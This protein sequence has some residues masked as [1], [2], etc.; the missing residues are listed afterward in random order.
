MIVV[1]DQSTDATA[2]IARRRRRHRGRRATR[3]PDGWAGKA[4]ALQQ[5]ID[6]ARANGSSRS[7]PTPGPTPGCPTAAGRPA[8]RRRL[9][10]L[11]V[12]GRFE[13]PTPGRRW[14]H[15]S[16]LTTLVYRF[17]P[18]GTLG[19]HAEPH[20]GER[21]VHGVPSRPFL[22]GRR[23][24]AV[25]GEVVEDVALARHLA[26][27]GAGRSTFLDAADR[28][29][30]CG[31]SSRSSDVPDGLG[32]LARPARCR[33][34]GTG[35]SSTSPSSCSPRRSRCRGC[36]PGVPMPSTSCCSPCVPARSSAPGP[37]TP[38][39]GRLLVLAGSRPRRGRRDRARHRRPAPDLARSQLP[40][41]SGVGSAS[42]GR[43]PGRPGRRTRPSRSADRS[44]SSD[45]RSPRS[46]TGRRPRAARAG[47]RT[48]RPGLP[49][50]TSAPR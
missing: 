30:P 28:C 43:R 3:C 6:A 33:A 2:A 34:L 22:A 21:A 13:C 19:R 36:S 29:S 1:D 42:S 17:G 20:D 7:T 15:P 40:L 41:R 48:R 32:A 49:T 45:T 35:S 50:R 5:G 38:A 10:F 26:A 24:A 37:R 18:P 4:W 25:A 9:D 12:G 14:L 11:T 31:C 27:D 47:R 46:G 39:D 44:G 16:M 8:A 23:H